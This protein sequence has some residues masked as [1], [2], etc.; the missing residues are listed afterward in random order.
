MTPHCSGFTEGAVERRWG[1]V[2]GNLD[3]LVRGGV[4]ENVV[5]ET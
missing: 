1:S 5:A 3:R 2:A 4:L